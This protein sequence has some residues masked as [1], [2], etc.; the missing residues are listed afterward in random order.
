MKILLLAKKDFPRA[1]SEVFRLTAAVSGFRGV[2]CSSEDEFQS[3]SS[4]LSSCEELHYL[5]APLSDRKCVQSI[6]AKRGFVHSVVT[7]H[8]AHPSADEVRDLESGFVRHLIPLR[9]ATD[10]GV[11]ALRENLSST[12]SRWR[13]PTL[14]TL[15]A[16]L[17]YARCQTM[18]IRTQKERSAA[19][20]SVENTLAALAPL[21]APRFKSTFV[22]RC[23][24]VVDEFLLNAITATGVDTNAAFELQEEQVVQLSFGFDGGTFGVS[25]TD[26][27]G[28]LRP[29]TFFRKALGV[30]A[31]SPSADT[32]RG[33]SLALGLRSSL[34][35]SR[36][37]VAQVA[38][39]R[40][41]C[42]SAFV[43]YGRSG[44][45]ASA[46]SEPKRL[47]YF[48]L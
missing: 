36:S 3:E 24:E 23:L 29:W 35:V 6:V 42:I 1:F 46:V 43:S 39:R 20:E 27:A 21:A 15:A 33:T 25:V 14:Q 10:E 4:R 17:P 2:V 16:E 34:A 40:F 7:F 31:D 37:L 45:A 11:A 13:V 48:A 41:T 8:S 30:D 44:G 12:F 9:E 19:L 28:S 5:V 18:Q 22:S 32:E 47:E 26:Q 38:P